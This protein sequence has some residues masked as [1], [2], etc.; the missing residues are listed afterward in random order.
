MINL[1]DSLQQI[2]GSYID[3]LVAAFGRLD[4]RN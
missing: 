4:A 2:D 1:V 3:T